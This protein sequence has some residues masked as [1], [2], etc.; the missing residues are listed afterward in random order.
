MDEQITYTTADELAAGATTEK[1]HRLKSGRWVRIRAMSRQQMWAI[2]QVGAGKPRQIE[3]ETIAASLV[4]P[5]MTPQQ[6]GAWMA[7]DAAGGDIAELTIAI[8]DLSGLGEDAAKAAY[9]SV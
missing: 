5:A 9:K 7:A 8:R 4:T 6:V 3:Q 1:D 2:Q